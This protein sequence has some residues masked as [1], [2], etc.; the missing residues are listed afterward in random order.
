MIAKC[1]CQHC[2][3]GIEFDASEL[4]EENCTVVC[5]HCGQETKLSLN[6]ETLFSIAQDKSKSIEERAAAF[7][8][9]TVATKPQKD[10]E[11]KQL[12]EIVKNMKQRQKFGRSRMN[13]NWST[14]R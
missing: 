3:G 1:D 5:P 10:A 11:L 12:E 13:W 4:T 6:A 2:N 9:Y 14:I 8:A 7:K